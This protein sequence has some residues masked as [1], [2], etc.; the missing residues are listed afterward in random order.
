M[1][2]R[3]WLLLIL[4]N[5]YSQ[6]DTFKH[7]KKKHGK[8][9]FNA[10]RSLENIKTKYSDTLLDNNFIESCDTEYILQKFA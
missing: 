2:L 8:D 3:F 5:L 6:K 4:I 10:V 9:I 1:M 7:I